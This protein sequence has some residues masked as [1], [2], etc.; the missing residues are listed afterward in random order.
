MNKF[1]DTIREM[2]GY[3]VLWLTQALSHLGSSMTSFALI[4]WSYQAEGSALSTA[5]LSVCSYAP[6]VLL[7][8][9]AGA[10]SDRWNK[11]ATLIVC[12]ALAAV[13]TVTVLLLLHFDA[14]RIW[15]LYVINAVNGLMNTVQQPAGEV[16]VSLLTPKK[17]YQRAGS[18][19]QLSNSITTIATPALAAALF[20]LAGLKIVLIVDLATFV[21]AAASLLFFI[22]LP[23]APAAEKKEKLWTAVKGGL[24]FLNKNRGILM[25]ILF[26]AGI[27]LIASIYNAALPALV[28]NKAD[29]VGY[30]ILNTATGVAMLA[31]SLLSTLMPDTKKRARMVCNT[32]L[33][34]MS[35]ENFFLA[36]GNSVPVWCIGAVC[37]WLV[38]PIMNANLGALMRSNIPVELQGRVYSV[39]NT[40]QFFTIPLGYLVGGALVDRVFEPFMAQQAAGGL[41][42]KLFGTGM[43]SGAALLYFCIALA[44][45]AICLYFRTNKH[46][47]AMDE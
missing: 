32:L 15:H 42:V 27:N 4:V 36:L 9:F 8:V 21:L 26:L 12:D 44:G 5:L 47:R 18:L 45:T 33:I 22:K 19:Q 3:L 16:A 37:G 23:E 17:H 13:S 46:I 38:I 41:L 28:L 43:G 14:L 6:Y 40:L 25:L 30:G 35:T 20:A 10:L 11:K 34:S 24:E 39:R 29:E 2:R 7:S 31:G 1:F